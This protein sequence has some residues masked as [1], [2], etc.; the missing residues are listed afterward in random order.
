MSRLPEKRRNRVLAVLA[1][2]GVIGSWVAGAL[3]YGEWG[4]VGFT[5]AA[6]GLIVL[7][8]EVLGI[9]VGEDDEDEEES[10]GMVAVVAGGGVALIGAFVLHGRVAI[11]ASL[12]LLIV[13]VGTLRALRRWILARARADPR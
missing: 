9:D 2:A 6:V 1:G 11:A 3:A 4:A 7:G 13:L 8:A 12:P 5:V 10:Q